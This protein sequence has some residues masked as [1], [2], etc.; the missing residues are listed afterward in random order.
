MNTSANLSGVDIKGVM[1]SHGPIVKCVILRASTLENNSIDVTADVSTM[2]PDE[3]KRELSSYGMD[4]SSFAEEEELAK[5]LKN[6]RTRLAEQ[7]EGGDDDDDS[8]ANDED[9]APL[10]IVPLQHLIEQ[11]TIDTTPKK[12]M[13]TTVLGGSFTFLGQYEEE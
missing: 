9:G 13:V 6:A 10:K 8:S 7:E 2:K 11:I 5:A 1:T 3:M 12:S 4:A